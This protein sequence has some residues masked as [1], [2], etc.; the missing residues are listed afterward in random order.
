[1]LSLGCCSD[2]IYVL[3]DCT[4]D[5]A[6]MKFGGLVSTS[7]MVKADIVTVRS[8][9]DLLWTVSIKRTL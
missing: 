1:M 9:A 7:N 5:D 8:D 4:A 6:E 3:D 2:V